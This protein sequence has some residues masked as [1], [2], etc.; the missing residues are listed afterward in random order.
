MIEHP[1][2]A[3]LDTVAQVVEHPLHQRKVFFRPPV[4]LVALEHGTANEQCGEHVAQTG[5]N[6]LAELQLAAEQ[7]HRHIG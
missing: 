4:I 2:E 7:R 5:G 6:A 1:V 3:V